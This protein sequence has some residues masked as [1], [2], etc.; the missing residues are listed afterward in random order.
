MPMSDE[1]FA[2]YQI[3]Y[4]TRHELNRLYEQQIE[5]CRI[6]GNYEG[7]CCCGQYSTIESVAASE[8]AHPD[9]D[10]GLLLALFGA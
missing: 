6:C 10:A 3:W 4:R 2:A 9:S 7:D 8:A 1:E 5:E